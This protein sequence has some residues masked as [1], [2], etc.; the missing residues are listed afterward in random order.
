M[1]LKVAACIFIGNIGRFV[2]TRRILPPAPSFRCDP[3]ICTSSIGTEFVLESRR[4]VF[5]DFYAV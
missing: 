3:N 1:W 5:R 4:I 2:Y